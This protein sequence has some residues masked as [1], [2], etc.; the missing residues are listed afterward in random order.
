[1]FAA[2]ELPGVGVARRARRSTSP[3]SSSPSG[4]PAR[5]P[6]SAAARCR[7]ERRAA[8]ARPGRSAALSTGRLT[9]R[10]LAALTAQ[11]IDVTDVGGGERV[12]VARVR[13]AVRAV[14][15]PAVGE[16][17]RVPEPAPGRAGERLSLGGDAGD[18][19]RRELDRK[20]TG[21]PRSAEAAG[22]ERERQERDRGERDRRPRSESLRRSF[23]GRPRVGYRQPE[24]G[25]SA[26]GRAGRTSVCSARA[27]GSGRPFESAQRWARASSSRRSSGGP[28]AARTETS[29]KPNSSRT[30][31]RAS[32]AC[33]GA[34]D[35]RAAPRTARRLRARPGR[36][37][38]T[39]SSAAAGRPAAAPA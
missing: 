2:V 4:P 31:M 17:G 23:P 5:R 34:G 39:A 24:R 28:A 37:R 38:G 13:R 29:S 7:P 27:A 15:L 8:G 22:G 14:T 36:G 18:R 21:R 25:A 30:S 1:M 3:A 9:P 12:R 19:G 20:P 33:T 6:R 35:R 10:S 32:A 26:P 16:A 11:V